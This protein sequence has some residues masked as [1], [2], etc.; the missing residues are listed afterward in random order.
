MTERVRERF[1][2]EVLAIWPYPAQMLFCSGPLDGLEDLE[3]KKVRVFSSAL[4]DLVSHFG[5]TGVTLAFSEVYPS[6]QRGVI[7]CA[8][9]ASLSGNEANWFEV[10]DT[11]YS[12]PMSWA[13]QLHVANGDFWEA[14]SE[15]EQAEM[16]ALFADM[17]ARMW[18]VAEQATQ[19]GVDCSTG[20]EPCEI[21][22]PADMTL[23]EYGAADEALLIEAVEQVVLPGWAEECEAAYPGC[24]A[25]WN[26]TVGATT[27][28]SIE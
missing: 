15:D 6:L 4:N 17:E 28:F 12:L 18:S 25:I 11:L 5:A 21:G 24:T 16:A 13:I 1:D 27:G 20:A 23:S 10:T 14:L 3:G 8:V 7:D 2:G 9:T 26:E 22:T 19:D